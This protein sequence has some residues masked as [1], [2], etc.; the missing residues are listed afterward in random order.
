MSIETLSADLDNRT[1]YKPR[2]GGAVPAESTIA[3]PTPK[4]SEKSP[5]PGFCTARLYGNYTAPPSIVHQIMGEEEFVVIFG[6]SGTMK[7]FFVLDMLLHVATG[8]EYYGRPVTKSGVLLIVG[9]GGGGIDRRVKAWLIAHGINEGD[10]QPLIYVATRPAS[11]LDD[12]DTIAVTIEAAEK[13]LGCRVETVAFDTLAANFGAGD[14]NK[15]SDM[16][17]AVNN[18][19]KVSDGRA[20]VF[21]HHSGLT[22]KNRERGSSVLKGAADVRI[23]IT[24]I[25]HGGSDVVVAECKKMKD[26][27]EF[28]PMAFNW[29]TVE[30]GWRDGMGKPLTSLVLAKTDLPKVSKTEKKRQ[31]RLQVAVIA[32]LAKHGA[33]MTRKDLVASIRAADASGK[34]PTESSVYNA[35]GRLVKDGSLTEIAGLIAIAT[36]KDSE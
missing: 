7:T 28:A 27:P 18:A 21:I 34:P 23:I 2:N 36:A 25:K 6:D 5:L 3:K 20:I 24:R 19:K 11:L 33:G 16:N 9:E 30:L 31:G 17:T 8:T 4:Q 29:N 1:V 13:V 26:G 15:T 12:P 10:V 14:E 35:V 32:T 22:D